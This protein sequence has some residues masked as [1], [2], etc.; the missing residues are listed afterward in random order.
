MIPAIFIYV[1]VEVFR[2][3]TLFIRTLPLWVLLVPGV[4][5]YLCG[6]RFVKLFDPYLNPKED[7]PAETEEDAEEET[8]E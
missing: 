6:K 7:K 1:S 4:L 2:D 3:L 5:A 8:E